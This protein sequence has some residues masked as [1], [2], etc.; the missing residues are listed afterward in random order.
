MKPCKIVFRKFT[1]AQAVNFIRLS[2]VEYGRAESVTNADHVRWKHL[3][4]PCGPSTAMNLECVDEVVGRAMLQP[5]LIYLSGKQVPVAFMSDVLIHPDFRRPA[6]NFISLMQSIKKVRDFP[7]AIHTANTFNSRLCKKLLKF[8]WPFSLRAFGFP[9]NLRK[10]AFKVLKFDSPLFELFSTPYRYLVLLLCR[11]AGIFIDLK[12]TTEEPDNTYFDEFCRKE[13][14]KNDCEMVRDSQFLKWRYLQSPLWQAKILYLYKDS[15]LC[16]YVV[17]R[18]VELEGMRFTVV[19]DFSLN[20]TVSSLQLLYLRCAIIRMALT[21]G[22]DM[23][24][25]LLNPLSRASKSFIGFPW[26]KIPEGYMPQRTPIFLHVNDPAME[27]LENQSSIHI[28]L[29]DL[30]YF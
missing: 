28:T 14:I 7:L 17:L 21:H 19:M 2:E 12:I 8:K 9:L 20:E 3:Q 18:N 22:D 13:A 16:G 6:S 10:T 29:G 26:I 15:Q 25:T 1:E 5:R 11:T 30:D 23:V 4:A 24:F 27:H